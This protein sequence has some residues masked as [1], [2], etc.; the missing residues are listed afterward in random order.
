M[1]SHMISAIKS[2]ERG[3]GVGITKLDVAVPRAGLMINIAACVDV[4][5]FLVLGLRVR[6]RDRRGAATPLRMEHVRRV[7]AIRLGI[8]EQI[9]RARTT[10]G[11]V[12]HRYVVP[13]FILSSTDPVSVHVAERISRQYY[14]AA[15]VPREVFA[16]R[17]ERKCP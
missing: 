7:M 11:C 16:G 1:I 10:D 6:C 17:I 12:C 15:E 8:N 3:H 9:P 5:S 2:R 13:G 4:N 14:R